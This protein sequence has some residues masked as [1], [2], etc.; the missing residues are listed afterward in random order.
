MDIEFVEMIKN[1]LTALDYEQLTI[2]QASLEDQMEKKIDSNAI[3]FHYANIRDELVGRF[4]TQ[5]TEKMPVWNRLP[6]GHKLHFTK[7]WMKARSTLKKLGIT[8]SSKQSALIYYIVKN[9]KTLEYPSFYKVT[10][11][12]KQLQDTIQREFP[13]YSKD[14]FM[15]VCSLMNR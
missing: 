2:I 6:E 12:L 5:Q 3:G 8:E 7:A 14:H 9:S 11:E 13:G 10:K 15:L 1:A 4:G